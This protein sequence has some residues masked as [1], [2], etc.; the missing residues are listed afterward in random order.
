ML[1]EIDSIVDKATSEVA[2]ADS[3]AVL[4]QVRVQ[5]LGKK[6]ALTEMLKAI[7]Q[8]DASERPK[9]GQI[10]NQAKQKI[11]GALNERRDVLQQDRLQQQ[12]ASEKIDVTLPGRGQAMGTIH[13]INLVRHRVETYFRQIGYQVVEGPEIESDYYNFEALNIPEHHPARALHDTFYISEGTLLRTHTSPMQIR[14]LEQ[15]PPPVRVVVPGRVYRCDSDVTHTPM[16]HQLEGLVIDE[17]STFADLKGVLK[18]F[19][20]N[21]FERD[22]KMRF[23][24][25]YFPFTEPSAEVDIECVNCDGSG[26]RVCKQSGW[27]EI[28]GCGMV[29]PNV[30][31]AVNLDSNRYQGFAFGIGLDRLAMLRY[32]VDDLRVFFDNDVR[33]LREF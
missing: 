1:Q 3:E 23:R 8:L 11:H 12:L 6:G 21:Y 13:P 24:P 25:S 33:F 26:C 17:H 15:Q 31:K 32:K 14:V 5:Y 7:G 16:F 2:Q 22:L 30:L 29:H 28:L 10:I 19:I 9:A 20:S 18:S 4:E 27:L